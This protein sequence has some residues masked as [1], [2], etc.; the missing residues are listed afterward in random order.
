[1]PK[2]CTVPKVLKIMLA[3]FI[4][5][6]VHMLFLEITHIHKSTH[7]YIHTHTHTYCS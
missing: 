1:M 4:E 2:Y 6:F 5:P 3:G 7:A